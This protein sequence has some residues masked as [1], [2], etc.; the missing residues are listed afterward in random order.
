[1]S[2]LALSTSRQS[3][4]T[5]RCHLLLPATANRRENGKAC[6]LLDM[7]PS[8]AKYLKPAS[9]NPCNAI[10][11]VKGNL[12]GFDTQIIAHEDCHLLHPEPASFNDDGHYCASSVRLIA[13]QAIDC[14]AGSCTIAISKPCDERIFEPT[15]AHLHS[16]QSLASRSPLAKKKRSRLSNKQRCCASDR[17]TTCS[18]R[19]NT[20]EILVHPVH[21]NASA[22]SLLQFYTGVHAHPALVKRPCLRQRW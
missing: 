22:A 1:M 17:R 18:F 6:S 4:N 13:M 12:I 2:S 7:I 10:S 9:L 19:V 8:L 16:Q 20:T 11:L 5:S 14:Y 21:Y 15:R 3:L